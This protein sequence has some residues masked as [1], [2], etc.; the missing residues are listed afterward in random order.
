MSSIA[1]F[2]PAL[3]GMLTVLILSLRVFPVIYSLALQ[4]QEGRINHSRFM[5]A[6][7][8]KSFTEKTSHSSPV[9]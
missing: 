8:Y 5:R 4:F 7:L 6:K 2:A 3:G 1:S 9:G